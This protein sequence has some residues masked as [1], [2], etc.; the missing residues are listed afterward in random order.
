MLPIGTQTH[1]QRGEGKGNTAVCDDLL[2][3]MACFPPLPISSISCRLLNSLPWKETLRASISARILEMLH[4]GREGATPFN[5]Q[6]AQ[7]H[8]FSL[9]SY[10]EAL[11][12]NFPLGTLCLQ[13]QL[14]EGEDVNWLMPS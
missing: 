4:G 1:T 9:T 12:E 11:M 7:S 3:L 8:L 14:V 10:L 2:G 5:D 13:E 6:P